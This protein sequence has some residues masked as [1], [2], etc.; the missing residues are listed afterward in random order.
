M[1]NKEVRNHLRELIKNQNDKRKNRV[2]HMTP[3]RKMQYQLYR[4]NGLGEFF[5]GEE[6]GETDEYSAFGM[7]E[8][9]ED[10]P[11]VSEMENIGADEI[12]AGDV[13]ANVRD[14]ALNLQMTRHI[15]ADTEEVDDEILRGDDFE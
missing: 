1:T 6:G 15:N 11:I 13:V 5:P 3:S 2:A 4:A 14:S 10:A 12:T 8:P 7:N 9:S